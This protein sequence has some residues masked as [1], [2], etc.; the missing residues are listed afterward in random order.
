MAKYI[1]LEKLLEYPI[2]L[3]HYDKEHG[4][5]HFVYGIESVMDYAENLPT[6][7]VVYCKDCAWHK[8]VEDDG[9]D[10]EV[11]NYYN[12]E[13]MGYQFCSEAVPYKTPEE[14]AEFRRSVD[15]DEEDEDDQQ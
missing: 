13:V 2:R 1:C 6:E 8:D 4:N 11:C 3:N 9:D 14:K 5:I 12:R 15:L 7:D 10:F